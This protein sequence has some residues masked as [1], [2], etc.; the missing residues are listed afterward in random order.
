MLYWYHMQR[1]KLFTSKANVESNPQ[2]TQLFTDI[3]THHSRSC[4]P[5]CSLICCVNLLRVEVCVWY[6]I[7]KP[8]Y[9]FPN[10]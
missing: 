2:F 10:Q 1:N 9:Q 5:Q 6:E 8:I 3:R 4:M 7:L